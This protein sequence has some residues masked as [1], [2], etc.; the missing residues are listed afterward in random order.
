MRGQDYVQTHQ[1]FCFDE[2]KLEYCYNTLLE[3][4]TF[5]CG[6][7]LLNHT[8]IFG[9]LYAFCKIDDFLRCNLRREKTTQTLP[10]QG[11]SLS[12]A[13]PVLAFVASEMCCLCFSWWS[14]IKARIRCQTM[15]DQGCDIVVS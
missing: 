14:E 5:A 11:E 13:A 10:V 1:A 9:L 6:C 15:N 2:F 7:S 3:R 4:L 8:S 12:V